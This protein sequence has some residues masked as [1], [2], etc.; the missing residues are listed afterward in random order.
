MNWQPIE[1]APKD[2]DTP[3]LGWAKEWSSPLVTWFDHHPKCLCWIA[4]G[5]M[6]KQ[7]PPTHW[8]PLPEPPK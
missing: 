8:M 3:I 5:Y 6:K 1:T 2:R 4:G 7:Y